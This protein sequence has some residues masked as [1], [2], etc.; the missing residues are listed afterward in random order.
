MTIL[1]VWANPVS[2]DPKLTHTMVTT[3]D[4]ITTCLP[5]SPDCYW[6]C[7]GTCH[8]V[9]KSPDLQLFARQ[10]GDLKWAQCVTTPND[11]TSNEGTHGG[12]PSFYGHYGVCHQVAN[13]TLIATATGGVSPITVKG[14]NGSGLSFFLYGVYATKGSYN[15]VSMSD[16]WTKRMGACGVTTKMPDE[17]DLLRGIIHE[18][19]REDLD[20]ATLLSV[21]RVFE[22]VRQRKGQLAERVLAGTLSREKFAVSINALLTEKLPELIEVLGADATGRLFDVATEGEIALLDPLIARAE[23]EAE[24]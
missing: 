20:E 12:I 11:A 10:D 22:E 13:R 6:F 15:G 18:T 19:L 24:N 5:S 16:N 1:Y 2:W 21:T 14:V 17:T 23:D 3:Y 8:I 9:S 7:W 4:P